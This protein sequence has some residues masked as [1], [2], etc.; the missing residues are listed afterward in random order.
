VAISTGLG[1]GSRGRRSYPGAVSDINVT[2]FVDVLLVVLVIFMMTSHVMEFGIEVDVPA[3]RTTRESFKELP[4]VTV[5]RDG[6]LYLGENRVNINELGE[7]V[8]NKYGA[9]QA[10]YLRADKQTIYDPI[11]QVLA[12]LGDAGVAVNMVTKP[13]EGPRRR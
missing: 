10:V 7:V 12:A 3:V 6:E 2:P 13:D 9:G 11:A 1:N 8:K 5:T 4:I